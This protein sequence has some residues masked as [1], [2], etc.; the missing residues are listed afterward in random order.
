M[1]V[2]LKDLIAQ[3]LTPDV[4]RQ[5]ATTVGL[6]DGQGKTFVDAA[7]PALLAAFGG[8]LD[9]PD[10]AKALSDAVSNS[11]PNTVEKLKRALAARDLQPLSDGANALNPV[12][13]QGVRDQ[14]A[15]GLASLVDAPVEAALPALG[16]VEQAAVAVIGQLDPSM[17][18]D[19]DSI[20]ALL[21][22]QKAAVLAALPPA[23]AGI[24]GGFGA[25]KAPPPP[26][27]PPPAA[28]APSRAAPPPP[29]PPPPA[30]G[31]GLIW[32]VVL[33]VIV[34]AAAAG[35]YFWMKSQEKPAAGALPQGTHFALNP[36]AKG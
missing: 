18:S 24:A 1:D 30:S 12:L 4:A 33:I 35:Y 16:A 5:L 20:K 3:V 17:W 31:G 32:V 26:P 29:P 11:D 15:T 19:A 13:G 8:A 14:L 9:R 22:S 10:G 36:A 6:D 28:A 2:D 23:L 21:T 34:I 25:A 27:A 7:I